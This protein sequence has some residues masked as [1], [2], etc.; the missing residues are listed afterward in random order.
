ML[1]LP[2]APPA[3]LVLIDQQRTAMETMAGEL[4]G[5]RAEVARLAAAI[6][7][8]PPKAKV[9]PPRRWWQWWRG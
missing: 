9:S 4:A 8:K 6:E 7:L 1:A 2:E 5:L 3:L